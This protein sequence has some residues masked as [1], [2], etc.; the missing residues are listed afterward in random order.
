MDE[1]TLKGLKQVS[2]YSNVIFT[3][4]TS[5]ESSCGTPMLVAAHLIL[6]KFSACTIETAVQRA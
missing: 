2:E 6:L 4:S 3:Y 1:P 5:Q